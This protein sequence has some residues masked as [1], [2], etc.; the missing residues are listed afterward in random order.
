MFTT[1]LSLYFEQ[2]YIAF[3]GPRGHVR[4]QEQEEEQEGSREGE[5]TP[6]LEQAAEASGSPGGVEDGGQQQDRLHVP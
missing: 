6:G 4:E 5:E 3:S 2:K 1:L